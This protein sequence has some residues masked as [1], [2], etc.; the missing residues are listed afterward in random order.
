MPLFAFPSPP[1]STRVFFMPVSSL[2]SGSASRT[3]LG[4]ALLLAAL[5]FALFWPALGYDYVKLDD[6]QYICL[7]P[8]VLTGL[9]PTNIRWAF[10]TVHED[11]WLPLLWTSY[12]VDTELFGPEPFGYHLTNLLLHAANAVLLFWVL[13]RLTGSTWRSF[14]VAALFALHPLR[15]EAVVWITSRKDV[16]SGFFFLLSLWAHA[17]VSEHSSPARK[18]LLVVLMLAGLLS[19]AILIIL[20]FALLLLDWWPLRRA[21]DPWGRGAWKQW[22]PLLAEKIPLLLLSLVFIFINLHTH[23]AASGSQSAA[24]LW[25]RLGLI[26]PNYGDYLALIAWPARLS[27]LYPPNDA[28]V[29]PLLS[30]AFAAGLLAV[31]G[32][33]VSNRKSAP[34]GLVGALWFFLALFP[35]IRGVRLDPTAAYADRFTYLPSIG[36]GL[37]LVWGV[38]ALVDRHPRFHRPAVALGIAVLAACFARS[39][40]RLPS[41]KNSLTMFSELVEFAPDHFTAVSAYGFALMEAG[42]VEEALPQFARAAELRPDTTQ[43]HADYADAL[44]R[45]GRTAEAADWLQSALAARDPNCPILNSLLGYAQLDLGRAD[46][47]AAPLRKALAAHPRNL[48]WRIELVRALFE[49]GDE[50]AASTEIQRLQ[51]EGYTGLRSFDDLIPHYLN[52]WRGGEK[53][54]AWHFFSNNLQLRPDHIG[55]LNTAAWLLATDPA[56]PAPPTEAVRLA[57][58]AVELA[59]SPHAGLL[60]TLAAALAAAG[61]FEAARQ[62]AQQALGLALQGQDPAT[63]A[64]IEARLA[65]YRAGRPWRE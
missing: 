20:P 2:P 7:N 51:R 12:M 19:K 11:W 43:A 16:L 54:H 8:H 35:V 55:L 15:V 46:L 58:R 63:A 21:G 57:R 39:A 44:L 24:P 61:D 17:R 1:P 41:W 42:R 36:L 28:A 5:V 38:A 27:I 56:P 50:S 23:T 10:T 48:G 64:R 18:G 65:A 31:L 26:F 45:L 53:T 34:Y 52:W 9:T 40:A 29:H 62:T 37:A 14:F 22:K 32:V 3:R 13:F 47:A 6:D 25:V 33:L 60:D 59:P 4:L 30:A 49:A